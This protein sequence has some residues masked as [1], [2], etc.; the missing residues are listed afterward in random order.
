MRRILCATVVLFATVTLAQ[1]QNRSGNAPAQNR[2]N[3]P[4][5]TVT[6]PRN[7]ASAVSPA[8]LSD[9]FV[10]GPQDVLEISVW[11][12]PDFDTTV[13]VRPD[14]KIGVRL[15][16]DIQAAGLT[17]MQL[18]DRITQGLR[19][20][21]P[22]PVVTVIVKQINSQVVHIMGPG[23]N[24]IGPYPITGPMTVMELI[25]K[26]GGFTQY[27]KTREILIF[28]KEGNVNRRF[29]FNYETYLRGQAEQNMQLRNGDMIVVEE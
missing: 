18:K 28:R 21:V 24:R 4:A 27:A 2:G 20:Y 7:N 23:I 3:T 9:E 11:D 14:G 29:T 6:A 10:I 17:A 15:L 22:E 25:A 19:P 8:P 16:T 5:Q 26:A 13:A 12:E 1:A